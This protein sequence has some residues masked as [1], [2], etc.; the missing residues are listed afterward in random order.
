[1]NENLK[2]CQL[3]AKKNENE[4]NQ[5]LLGFDTYVFMRKKEGKKGENE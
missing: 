4:E 2:K 5:G 3:K 1:M